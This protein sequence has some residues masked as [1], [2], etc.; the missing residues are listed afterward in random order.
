MLVIRLFRTGKKNQP[1]FKIV[2]TDKRRPPRGGRF[3][4]QV[5]FLNPLT[6]EKKLNAERI[7]HWI[8]KGAKASDTVY[9]LLVK[10]KILEGKKIALH[11]K[12]K[13]KG[14]KKPASVEDSGEAKPEQ[15]PAPTEQPKSAEPAPPQ[16]GEVKKP[17]KEQPK[18]S[19]KE[20]KPEE[21]KTEEPKKEPA[22]I[23]PSAEIEAGKEEPEEPKNK[24][25]EI[26]KPKKPEEPKKA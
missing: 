19:A 24:E 7:K 17:A 9:N 22:Q 21:A 23:P 25:K 8:S 26:E 20:E 1:F 6:K 10:E 12:K 3:V 16:T 14:E 15:A 5:G 13:E 11:K 18:E 4:E 2:V